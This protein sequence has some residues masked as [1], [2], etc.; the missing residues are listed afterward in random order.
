MSAKKYD[1]TIVGGLGHVGLPLG[2]AFAESGFQVALVDPDRTKAAEVLAAKMP[3]KERGAD[4]L[5][6]RLIGQSLHV[7]NEASVITDSKIVILAIGTPVDEYLNPK[8]RAFLEI[9]E[10]IRNFL[11]PDQLIVVRSTV[12]PRTVQQMLRV[13][14][15]KHGGP[16]K[17]AYCPERIVQGEALVE[18]KTLPQIVSGNN[19]VAIA[20][21]KT[22]FEHLSPKVIVTSLPEAELVK[23]FSNAW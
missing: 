14:E 9:I 18:L 7:F 21:A 11:S 5:L 19:P 8:T 17:I 16:W 22:L 12:F 4:E 2:M 1:L 23:L 3:F 10:S 13:L 20:E 15:V 6:P